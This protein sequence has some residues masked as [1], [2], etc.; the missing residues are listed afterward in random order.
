SREGHMFAIKPMNC[1]HHTQIFASN[2]RSYRDMPHRYAETTMCYRDEQ[3]GELSGLSRLRGFTQDDAHVFCRHTQ[4]KE[5]F[6]KIWEIVDKFYSTFGFKLKVRLSLHDP[7]NMKA[8]LGTE[9]VWNKAEHILREIAQERNADYYEGVGEAAF[10]GPK[11]DFMTKDSLNREWQVATIQLDNNMPERFDLYCINE[12][13]NKE[14]IAMIHA[15]IMGSI[16]RFLSVLIEHLAG[17]FP[18]WLS[19][20][21]VRILTIADRHNLYADKVYNLLAEAGIRV[22][23]DFKA[24]TMNKKIRNAQLDQVNY[25]IV[26]GDKEAESNTVNVRTRDN[27]VQGEKDVNT[28]LKELLEE[29]KNKK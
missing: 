4:I 7:K 10:Y 21:Q 24:E 5:E 12:E 14:R 1:P 8:Y 20:E 16:E 22:E 28:F 11:I 17:K 26:I 9:E 2:S 6:V 25:I 15:A 23:K 19:P 29:I 3:S 13:G 18:L 27:I